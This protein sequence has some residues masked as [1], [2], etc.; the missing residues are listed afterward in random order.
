MIFDGIGISFTQRYKGPYISF[1]TEYVY[2]K[3]AFNLG[4][5]YSNKI[6]AFYEDRHHMRDFTEVSKFGNTTMK[7]IFLGASYFLD[8][9]NQISF[10]YEQSD[11]KYLRGD[12]LRTWDDGFFIYAE[13]SAATKSTYNSL[14]VNYKYI[15]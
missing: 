12:R 4:I 7:K 9:N 15:F 5:K 13:N 14:T 6:K 1:K 8:K 11:F 3:V 2:K 10:N